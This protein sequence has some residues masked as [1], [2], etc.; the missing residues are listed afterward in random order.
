VEEE[1]REKRKSTVKEEQYN[2]GRGG[3]K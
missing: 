1:A 3:G 2:S